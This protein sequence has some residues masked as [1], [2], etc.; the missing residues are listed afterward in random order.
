MRINKKQ[1]NYIIGTIFIVIGI[2]CCVFIAMF[3]MKLSPTKSTFVY[4]DRNDNIDS[5]RAKIKA[6]DAN[7]SM[8]AFNILV[9][10]IDY[11]KH[12]R[13][14]RYEVSD[15]ISTLRLFRNLRNHNSKPVKIVIPATRNV[16]IIAGILGK[17]LMSDSATISAKF[18]NPDTWNLLGYTKETFPALF[19]PNTYEFYWETSADRLIAKLNKENDTFWNKERI[20]KT[21]KIGLT[22]EETITLASIIDRETAN[23][24]EKPRIAGLYINRMHKGIMLQS[25]PTVIFAIGDYSIHRVTGKYL[26]INSPYNTYRVMGLPPGPICIPS[27]ASIDAVL[28]YEH[29]DYLYMCAKEDLS[30]THNFAASYTEHQNNARRYREMLNANEIK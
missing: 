8:T 7:I 13:P 22:K 19:I 20:K 16:D 27:I 3:F 29:N 10:F 12:I 26:Q 5:V 4:I 24:A 11:D 2:V 21:H 28:N 9:L 30:G 1:R 6:V 23:D 17:H 15:E 14:G 25:D 18:H